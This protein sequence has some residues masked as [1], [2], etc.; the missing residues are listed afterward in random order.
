MPS[1]IEAPASCRLSHDFRAA[2]EIHTEQLPQQLPAGQVLV[3][4]AW[5]GVNASDVNHSA[6]R[7]MSSPAE[8]QGKHPY[9]AGFEAVGA[10]AAVGPSVSGQHLHQLKCNLQPFAAI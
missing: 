10:V 4:R 9:G 3:R 6:G 8:A 2:T 5:A 1:S 7:Y